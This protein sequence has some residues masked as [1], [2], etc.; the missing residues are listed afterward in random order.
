MAR[1]FWLVM[2]FYA[3]AAAAAGYY[4]GGWG[5]TAMLAVVVVD[6]VATV[7]TKRIGLYYRPMPIIFEEVNYN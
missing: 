3:A 7:A 6:L 1:I 2:C 5:A 4:F